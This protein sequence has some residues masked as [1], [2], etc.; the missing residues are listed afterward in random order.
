MDTVI[1]KIYGLDKFGITMP[2]MFVP[3]FVI[4]RF[5][6]LSLT[7]RTSQTSTRPHLRRFIFKPTYQRDEYLPGIEIFEAI[8]DDRISLQ[9][10][11][12]LKFSVPKLLYGNSV[13]EAVEGD[14]D[15]VFSK[16]KSS[17][18]RAGIPTEVRHIAEA[19]ATAVHLCKNI[20]LPKSLRAEKI[21]DELFRVDI[22][23]AVDIDRKEMKQGGNVLNLW[24]GT[25]ER[26]F[27]EKISDAMRPKNKRTDKEHI[28]YERQIAE[29]Y[30]LKD[31]QVFRY[32]Y[33]LKSTQTVMSKINKALGR[34]YETPVLFKDLFTPGLFKT[35]VL[36]SWRDIIQ[37]PENK[38]ALFDT[39]D[40]LAFL[41]HI[42]SKARELGRS[43]HSQNKALI[44]YGL[45]QSI[46]KHGAKQVRELVDG[47]WDSD[48]PER[49]SKKIASAAELM[50]GIL[51]TNGIAFIDKA[52]EEFKL[53]DLDLLQNM[54][55]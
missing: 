18:S 14:K 4:R 22:S 9:Y 13:Q 25:R 40:D 46:K 16:L 29:R 38:L 12:Q 30:N 24:S 47:V 11:L 52:I 7:E 28:D 20:L 3:E 34:K 36:E 51:Y 15:A 21:L 23:K 31:R 26:V 44:A 17:L 5:S 35:M 32:E 49:F 33:R 41:L 1:I 45:A 53:I 43:A 42:L 48:H 39:E 54:V 19:R 2:S 8:A 37:K 50:Q 55:E 27:Y 6:E 10:I